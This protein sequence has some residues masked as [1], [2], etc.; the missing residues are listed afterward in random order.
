M[1]DVASI[2]VNVDV[3]AKSFVDLDVKLPLPETYGA[4][5]VFLSVD[6]EG[7]QVAA[8]CVRAM[9]VGPGKFFEPAFAIDARQPE[10]APLFN[11]IGIRGTRQEWGCFNM[12]DQKSWGVSMNS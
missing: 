1:R 5:A 11:R 10:V 2:P 12:D 8:T 9:K 4:F 7:T 6:G 3:P